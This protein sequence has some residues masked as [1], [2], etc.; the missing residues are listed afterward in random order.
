MAGNNSIRGDE[1]IT[2]T[3][4]MSFDGTERGGKMT[5]DG[6]LWIGSTASRHVRLGTITGGTGVTITNGPGSI[7]IGVSGSGIG[8]VTQFTGDSGGAQVPTGAGNFNLFGSGS[9]TTV[10]TANTETF[11]LTGLTN[12]AVLVGAGTTTITKLTV[13]TNGQ[14]LIGATAADPAFASLTSTG[15]TVTF[16]AG[17]NTLNLEVAAG[18]FVWNDVT[19][20]TQAMSIQN[21]YVTDRGAGVVYTLPAT[22]A[23]GSVIKVV[24]KLGLTT[25]TPNAN[26][27]ILLGSSSGSV[28]V[29]GTFVATNVG[30]CISLVATTGGSSTIWRADSSVGNWTIN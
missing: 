8:A 17:A 15:G 3:D 24:G 26:Q 11:Q 29:T 28:G 13:G 2:F 21:G 9:I 7:S 6:Q 30:D 27:Q 22:A 19:G 1:T 18:G 23:F 14:V 16:T 12:H 20:S 4:N 10:G 5:T 25:I